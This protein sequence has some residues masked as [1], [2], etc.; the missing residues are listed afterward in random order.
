M[1][2]LEVR[3]LKVW[4]P[5]RRG[6]FGR[7]VGE[8][9][10]VDGVS[11]DVAEG[12]TLGLVG[13]SGSGKTT[14]MR[15]VAGLVR[16]TAG[17]FSLNGRLGMVFQDP[18]GSL[19]PRQTVGSILAET[20]KVGGG[21]RTPAELL[22]MVGLGPEALDRYP[23][24]FSGGERQRICIARA[25]A[26]EPRLLVCDEA[27]SALDLSIRSQVLELLADL[28]RRL[29]LSM[30]FITHDLGVVRHVAD[31]VAVMKAGRIVERGACA[32]VL[33]RPQDAYT[34]ALVAAVPRLPA[35]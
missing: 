19:N 30:V 25:V 10:A 13:E 28:R 4:F 7:T 35:R 33:L 2:V 14:T 16:P 23:F 5:I 1:N 6:V 21:R 20:L 32:D 24:A 11:F 15:A 27:V 9:R 12:E 22:G 26:N 29:G 3:D 18:L 34:K 17:S 8:V 31:R